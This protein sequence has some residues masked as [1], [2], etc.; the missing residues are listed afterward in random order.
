MEKE[1]KDGTMK[2]LIA[3]DMDGTLVNKRL[4]VTQENKDA[5]QKAQKAGH[6]VVIATGRS[7]DEARFTLDEAQL[8]LPLICVNGAEILDENRKKVSSV[9]ISFERYEMMAKV[10]M[11]QDVY[12]EIYGSDGTYTND[13]EQAFEVMK[14]IVLTSNPEASEEDVHKAALMRF[15]LG[16]VHHI[17]S[18][19]TLFQKQDFEI[20]K[21]LAFSSHHEKLSKAAQQLKEM[22]DLAVSSSANN[23]LE[24]TNKAAQKGLALLDFAAHANI[25]LENTMAIGDN[26]ND[27]S[28]LEMAGT[29]VAMGNAEAEI[30]AI[31]SYVTKSNEES[32]VAHA[33]E[34]FIAE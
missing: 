31:A 32:G 25:S 18:Y 34:R 23:N 19:E 33:I 13:R 1:L 10:L 26:Y 2:K 6:I 4:K 5:I 24:I 12:F 29:S 15:K 30:K 20:Y 7:L 11:E 21:L 8:T 3:I 16:L 9:P 17:D 27:V 28:M 22:G 14:D